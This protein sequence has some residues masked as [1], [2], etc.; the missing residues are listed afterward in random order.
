M[1]QSRIRKAVTASAGA[2]LSRLPSPWVQ[3]LHSFKNE[4]R[5]LVATWLG[6]P[7]NLGQV[8]DEI[9]AAERAHDVVALKALCGELDR[10][11]L[12]QA[13]LDQALH[14]EGPTAP[15]CSVIIPVFDQHALTYR[16][17]CSLLLRKSRTT[18]E[19]II[20]DNGSTDRTAEVLHCFRKRVRVVRNPQNTGFVN[21][22][23]R[24]ASLAKGEFLVFLN[25]DTEVSDNWL[26][27]LVETA[28]RSA[29]VGAVGAKLVYPDG[30]LQEA[31]GI[32]WQDGTA[33]NYGNKADPDDLRFCFLREVDYC[34]AAC[35]LVRRQ[36]FEQLGGLDQRFAPAYWEDTDLCF[37]LRNLGYRVLYQPGCRI[38]HHEG[39]TAGTD[40]SVGL[41]RFQPINQEKF[42]EKWAAALLAQRPSSPP[43]IEIAA[44][45]SQGPRIL[46]IDHRIP[47]PDEDS[48]SVRAFA[49]ARLLAEKGCR[50]CFLLSPGSR[51]DGH[52]HALGQVGVQVVQ[53][54]D[55]TRQLGADSFDL[56]FIARFG[57]AEEYLPMVRRLAPLVP[58]VFDTVDVHFIREMRGA[59]LQQ[60]PELLAKAHRTQEQ[61]MS[62][63]RA[64]DLTIATTE[65]DRRHL[66]DA[67]PKLRVEVVPNIHVVTEA[68]A[69]LL[70][71]SGLMFIGGFEHPPNVDAVLYFVHEVL[72]LISAQLGSVPRLRIVG[73]R[74]PRE[75]SA[76]AGERIEVTGYVPDPAPYF[77]QSRV[78]VAPLRYGAGM[79]G[80]I[81]H[82]LSFGLP[83]VTTSIGAEGLNLVHG[84][85]TLIA[86]NP[87]NFAAAVVR[88][89]ED[90]ALW[91]ALS[92]KGRSHIEAHCGVETVR[93][94]LDRV[95]QLSLKNRQLG[96]VPAHREASRQGQESPGIARV[97]P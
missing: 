22:C 18:F 49:I 23:N 80:K 97:A 21:A 25:N 34:S 31:G 44:N 76:L 14:E 67:E 28:R 61:E 29:T 96:I 3:R 35:L 94:L 36:A 85:T 1:E 77:Q 82:A 41:K 15:V 43:D 13:L 66:L 32:V 68:I 83:V 39:G 89:H 51:I 54:E 27:C 56:V 42:Q 81:G 38:T 17:L 84:E 5:G 71:R 64:C 93:P 53:E 46:L 55:A 95:L 10:R 78:F 52:V 63:A 37:G 65:Q 16:C 69:P 73:S 9:A 30:R 57:V 92:L 20:V 11:A 72:P 87:Q 86:D 90:H 40:V 7:V 70:D 48:G 2:V 33:W 26:D 79:K 24:G 91:Q 45:R 12:D 59:A 60:D 47:R 6:D 4:A 58:V 88:L 62:V 74:P 50:V 75:V 19:I 8:R